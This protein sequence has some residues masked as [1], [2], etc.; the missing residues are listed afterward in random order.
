ME[1]RIYKASDGARFMLAGLLIL[2]ACA[3]EFL[4]EFIVS[5]FLFIKRYWVQ[6]GIVAGCVA[7]AYMTPYLI[8]AAC[9]LIV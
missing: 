7:L 1:K 8:A 6:I 4:Q 3:G 2:L 9:Y 5:A